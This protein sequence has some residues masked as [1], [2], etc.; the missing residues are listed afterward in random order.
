MR[1]WTVRSCKSEL[2]ISPCASC[3][4]SER[5]RALPRLRCWGS[6]CCV[7]ALQLPRTI[8]PPA[9]RSKREFI[10]KVGVVVEEIDE[11]VLWLDLITATGIM[12][13]NR[14]AALAKEAHELLAIFTASQ[15]TAK[16]RGRG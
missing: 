15:A 4:C 7:A 6:N 12:A 9:A 2:G 13:E 8:E 5:F 10:A 1:A 3:G 14:V 11:T 16:G